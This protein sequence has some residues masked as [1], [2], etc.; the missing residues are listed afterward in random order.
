M[1]GGHEKG[2]E[3]GQSGKQYWVNMSIYADYL[4]ELIGDEAIESDIGFATYRFTD[5]KTIYIVDI[6]VRPDFRKSGEASK[7]AD[8]VVEIGKKKGCTKVIGTVVPSR[9]GSTD[10]MKALLGY[11]FKLESSGNDFIILGKGI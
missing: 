11:G 3:T 8:Q 6:Y 7:F 5:E 1:H 9:K 4:K 10:S 2:L